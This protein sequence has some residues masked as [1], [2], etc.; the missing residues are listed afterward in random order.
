MMINQAKC[1]KLPSNIRID[2]AIPRGMVLS[3]E[4]LISYLKNN[5]KKTIAVGDVVTETLLENMLIPV[6]AIIDGHTRRGIE[7]NTVLSHFDEIL[8]LHNPPGL[9]T[10]EAIE[11]ICEKLSYEKSKRTLIVVEGEEDMLALPSIACSPIGYCIVYGVPGVGAA[12]IKVGE[13]ERYTASSR[14]LSLKPGEC[15]DS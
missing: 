3:G 10:Q 4:K 11:V 6:L 9:I 13:T 15:I 8:N 1:L 2:F 12:V 5:C 7:T 14:I